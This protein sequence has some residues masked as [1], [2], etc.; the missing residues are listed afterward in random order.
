MWSAWILAT[1]SQNNPY[2]QTL[3]SST[4]IEEILEQVL[5]LL[6][7]ESDTE[8][9]SKQIYALSSL[10]STNPGLSELFVA[11]SGVDLLVARM[12]H[13]NAGT[14]VSFFPHYHYL[15]SF[16]LKLFG[17]F[18]NCFKQIRRLSRRPEK[19]LFSQTYLKFLR[20]LRRLET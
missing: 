5:S 11:K 4:S 1:L 12:L 2:V 14:R 18:T 6:T 9:H 15:L 3:F 7:N 16:R 19:H 17:S 13:S 10:L 20:T 8:A